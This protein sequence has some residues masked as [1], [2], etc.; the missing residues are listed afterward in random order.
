MNQLIRSRK[1]RCKWVIRAENW[2]K[3][4]NY[5]KVA[6]EKAKQ[7]HPEF[8]ATLEREAYARQFLNVAAL[9]RSAGDNRA[10]LKLIFQAWSRAWPKFAVEFEAWRK[11]LGILLWWLPRPVFGALQRRAQRPL[12]RR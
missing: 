7:R 12:W 4:L 3:A 11:T 5:W 2:Q 9:A 6:V 10:A 8:V 1:S